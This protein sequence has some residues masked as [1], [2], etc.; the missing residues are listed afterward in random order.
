MLLETI[1]R[2]VDDEGMFLRVTVTYRD[3][4]SADDDEV[5]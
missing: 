3:A 2:V 5:R 4:Q 1:T